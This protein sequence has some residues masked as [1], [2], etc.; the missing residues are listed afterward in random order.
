ML[1][2]CSW[3]EYRFENMSPNVSSIFNLRTKI[4]SLSPQLWRLG[5]L[6]WQHLSFNAIGN[7]NFDLELK[8]NYWYQRWF[9]VGVEKVLKQLNIWNCDWALQR[10]QFDYWTN[11][12]SINTNTSTNSIKTNTKTNST[13][14]GVNRFRKLERRSLKNLLKSIQHQ[15]FQLQ[16]L[17]N[18]QPNWI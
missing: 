4:Q 9:D 15:T 13:S 5:Q 10:I 11:T 14:L 7:F 2:A 16:Q 3:I 12:N 1:R 6:F 17:T 18:L 8:W